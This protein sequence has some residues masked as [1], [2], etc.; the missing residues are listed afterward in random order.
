MKNFVLYEDDEKR[1]EIDGYFHWLMKQLAI[2]DFKLQPQEMNY[3]LALAFGVLKDKNVRLNNATIIINN[4]PIIESG[5][6]IRLQPPYDVFNGIVAALS[7][8]D[9]L[10]DNTPFILKEL[11]DEFASSGFFVHIFPH[12]IYDVKGFLTLQTPEQ[13][14]LLFFG[15]EEN[16]CDESFLEDLL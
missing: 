4:I 9:S 16:Y 8:Y 2:K 13:S 5:W 14:F 10:D 11:E 1:I 15:F 3:L 12:R 6:P 7:E